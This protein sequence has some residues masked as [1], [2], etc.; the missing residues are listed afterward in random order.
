L[1]YLAHI[2]LSH[3]K[4][5]LQIG[6]FIADFVKGSKLNA[7]PDRIKNGILL[8]RLI[9]DFTDK[10][11]VVKECVILLRPVFG[12]YAAIVLDMYFDYFL[13]KN[14]RLYSKNHSL[15][16]TAIKFYGTA[17][18]NYKFLPKK[19]KRFIFHFILSNRLGKYASMA[20]LENSLRIMSFHKISAIN[21]SQCIEFLVNHQEEL[22]L[23]F[24]LFFPELI[25]FCNLQRMRY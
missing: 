20:G 21:P 10:H 4:A 23:K 18:L 2:Y 3:N 1:N 13:A 17:L 14:F 25:Q 5:G 15:T 16:L 24:H 9:D 7:Y 22:E 11:P 12:R 6:N 8:H 19:V